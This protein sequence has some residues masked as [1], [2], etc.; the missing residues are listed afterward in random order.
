MCEIKSFIG[1][2]NRCQLLISRC[3]KPYCKE[4]LKHRRGW[5]VIQIICNT[6]KESFPQIIGDSVIVKCPS[7]AELTKGFQGLLRYWGS[8]KYPSQTVVLTAC[9]QHWILYCCEVGVSLHT[10]DFG[11]AVDVWR[12][13]DPC[14]VMG[15][16]SHISTHDDLGST[17]LVTALKIWKNPG[18]V[19]IKPQGSLLLEN[20]CGEISIV[21]RWKSFQIY[22]SVLGRKCIFLEWET[23]EF[24]WGRVSRFCQWSMRRDQSLLWAHFFLSWVCSGKTQASAYLYPTEPTEPAVKG[25]EGH[26]PVSVYWAGSHWG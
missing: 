9:M 6:E 23:H 14:E 12:W 2:G 21:E 11:S 1:W 10:L 13:K 22:S 24:D 16:W 19:E 15:Q 4:V 7:G 8:A 18:E 25:K 3:A 20:D 17:L 26:Y 5:F